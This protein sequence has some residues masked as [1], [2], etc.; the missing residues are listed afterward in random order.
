MW[1]SCT[2][3]VGKVGVKPHLLNWGPTHKLV[4]S[5]QNKKWLIIIIFFPNLH[6]FFLLTSL[7]SNFRCGGLFLHLDTRTH[8]QVVDSFGWRTGPSQ[9]LFLLYNNHILFSPFK[10]HT[11]K[12]WRNAC[13]VTVC[14]PRS[15]TTLIRVANVLYGQK[16]LSIKHNNMSL[17]NITWYLWHLR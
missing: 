6:F 8:T 3:D 13:N 10:W 4:Y 7:P 9:G 5:L 12:L 11:T 15:P 17:P 16:F 1:L 2:S 14:M